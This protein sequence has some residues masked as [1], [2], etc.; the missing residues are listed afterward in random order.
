[1]ARETVEGETDACLAMSDSN[2]GDGAAVEISNFLMKVNFLGSSSMNRSER[3]GVICSEL[4]E[5]IAD[6]FRNQ[7][8]VKVPNLLNNGKI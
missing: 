5:S 8:F 4:A 6:G 1:M 2:M 7:K 3:L